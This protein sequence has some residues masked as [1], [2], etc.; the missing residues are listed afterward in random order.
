MKNKLYLLLLLLVIPFYASA[1]GTGAH[2]DVIKGT[3]NDIGDEINCAGEHFYIIDKAN[4]K[5][6][7]LAKYNL[8]N[9]IVLVD[10]EVS[11]ERYNQLV[12]MYDDGNGVPMKKAIM[13]EPE[14]S[15]YKEVMSITEKQR[16]YREYDGYYF[17]I[18]GDLPN[19]NV[20][21]E[22]SL[23]HQSELAIGAHGN[24]LG[25]PDPVQ[26]GIFTTIGPNLRDKTDIYDGYYVDS[27]ETIQ[28]EL[29][30]YMYDDYLKDRNI[31]IDNIDLIS[32]K[33]IKNIV[34]KVSGSAL[35]L[36]DWFE[37]QQAL[38]NGNREYQD[39]FVLGNLKEYLPAGYEWLYSTSYYTKTGVPS[40]SRNWFQDNRGPDLEDYIYFVDTLGFICSKY[41]CDSAVGAGARPVVTID[42]SLLRYGIYTKVSGSG[43]IE[44]V[45]SA[46][47]GE[48][49]NFTIKANK[50]L[51]LKRL[52]I[53]TPSGERI[54]FT[55]NDITY[56]ED[57]TIT[58]RSNTFIMPK[59]SVTIE[60]E[61]S[62]YVKGVEE[63]PKTGLNQ[64]Y[65]GIFVLFAVTVISYLL[66]RR[67][68]YFKEM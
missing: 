68:E 47:P 6:K 35:P 66:I 64:L 20:S 9:G 50:D 45:S 8:L 63:N 21:D 55:E 1:A 15:I 62:D 67:K 5:T 13:N 25:K 49:I 40:I 2:C 65:I 36:K 48:L 60:A 29:Q 59:E 61:W 7:M 23:V 57:G 46:I 17:K 19:K 16:V 26:I 42:D 41:G 30:L 3:G 44:V 54:E 51:E 11:E 24:E 38:I 43:S 32:L 39:V 34:Y 52:A 28:T 14:F 4:N 22:K 31:N 27:D 56:N 12:D 58:I 33:E 53:V 18:Y 37:N 10:V